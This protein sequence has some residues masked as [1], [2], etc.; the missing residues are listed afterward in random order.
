VIESLSDIQRSGASAFAGGGGSVTSGTS[1]V[2]FGATETNEAQLVVTGQTGIL[3]GS[4]VTASIG[5][6]ATSD[7]TANDHKYL[8]S[9]GVSVTSGAVVAG[10][11]FTIYVRSYQKI[12]GDISIN[13]V[14]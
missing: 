8:G 1:T 4:K 12:K 11:G 3:A 13:W 9:M 5:T 7:Y 6:T 14:Y 2:S 10:T